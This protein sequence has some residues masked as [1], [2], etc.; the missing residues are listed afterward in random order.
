MIDLEEARREL[1]TARVQHAHACKGSPA[2]ERERARLAVIRWEGIVA[3][4]EYAESLVQVHDEL[5]VEHT[6]DGLLL[7][8]PDALFVSFGL[9]EALEFFEQ[10]AEIVRRR[11]G[12]GS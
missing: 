11:I 8:M 5:S 7:H 3:S 10:G 9:G 2:N 12:G 4:A 6:A 1:A